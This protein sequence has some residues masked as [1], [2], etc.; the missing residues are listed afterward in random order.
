MGRWATVI[1]LCLL[2]AFALVDRVAISMMVGPIKRD[3]GITDLQVGVLM[4]GA[5]ALTFV[6]LATPFGF[7]ADRY[8]R[9]RIIALG[10][11]IWSLATLAC[12]FATGF[13]VLFLFRALVGVG[14]ASITPVSYSLISDLFPREQR[15]L[16]L[17]IYQFGATLGSA[18]SFAAGGA[19]LDWSLRHADLL[20]LFGRPL[21][22]WQFVFLMVGAP[23]VLL[24]L[25]TWFLPEPRETA[26][27]PPR[28]EAVTMRAYFLANW[29]LL[30]LLAFTFGV[31]VTVG[32][33]LGAW[34][35]EYM[36]RQFGWSKT[37]VGSVMGATLVLPPLLGGLTSGWLMDRMFARGAKDAPL[38][39]YLWMTLISLPFG[40]LAFLTPSPTVM[41]GSLL[42]LKIL[43]INGVA[44]G[45]NALQL[46]CPE[47]IRGRMSGA[48]LT[49]VNFIGLM[50]GPALV[51]GLSDHFSKA[52]GQLGVALAVVVGGGIALCC[53]LL[54]LT[55]RPLR[56]AV[57]AADRP[58]PGARQDVSPV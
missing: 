52:G 10:L 35:P 53:L 33:S 6:T 50:V 55:L 18:V 34:T 3:L 58:P 43:F 54:A 20:V 1:T 38:R 36:S 56:G 23:G 48:Y 45:S 27:K 46:F 14:E 32:Y 22:P 19:L 39:L 41:I 57:T 2:Y 44:F 24:L 26:V 49:I 25:T 47:A 31:E 30:S 42:V 17:S 5:F 16:P 8:P 28:Q 15:G 11:L 51:G 7:L 29:G 37:L 9:R 21:F 13:V 12:G 40:I 4:G